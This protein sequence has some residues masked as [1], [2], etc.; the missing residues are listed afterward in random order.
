MTAV[1]RAWWAAS[2]PGAFY[3]SLD[4]EVRLRSAIAVA[5]SAALLGSVLAGL[6]LARASGSAPGPFLLTVPALALPYLLI[7]GMLGSFVLMR[8]A[9]LDLRAF[10]IV[11]W[12]WVPIGWLALAVAPIGLWAPG[13]SL[14]V[15][16]LLLPPWH[17]WMV[18]SGVVVH[19]GARPRAAV[20]GY[21]L[22]VFGLPLAMATFVTAILS[23]LP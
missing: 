5:A 6:L 14:A 20:I 12:A 9:E 15:A 16:A 19:A 7:L 1:R 10:E 22:T 8:P 18:W 3:A 2:T 11:A 4:E 23:S 13:P 17:L 21:G